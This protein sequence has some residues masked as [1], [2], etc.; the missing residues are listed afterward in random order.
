MT[1]FYHPII[2]TVGDETTDLATGT[3]KKTFRM[4]MAYR[5][6]ELP[7]ASLSTVATGATLVAIDINTDGTTLLSTKITLDASE[8]TSFTAATP[9]VLSL[10]KIIQNAQVT[11][12]IDAVGNTTTGKGLKV[13]LLGYYTV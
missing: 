10:R 5:L 11:I 9:A 6:S 2:L 12:D 3:A 7:R 8:S 4:P 1:E 13:E